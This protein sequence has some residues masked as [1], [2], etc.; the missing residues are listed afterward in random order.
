MSRPVVFSRSQSY[1]PRMRRLRLILPLC[2]LLFL[3]FSASALAPEREGTRVEVIAPSTPVLDDYPPVYIRAERGGR[4]DLDYHG[5]VWMWTDGPWIRPYH[6]LFTP[7]DQGVIRMPM[8]FS[9]PVLQRIETYELGNGAP[10]STWSN[11][12]LPVAEG[13]PRLWW[14]AIDACAEPGL[15][16]CLSASGAAPAVPGVVAVGLK[17]IVRRVGR[18]QWRLV[19]DPDLAEADRDALEARLRHDNDRRLDEAIASNRGSLLLLREEMGGGPLPDLLLIPR[20]T[21]ADAIAVPVGAQ[22]LAPSDGGLIGAWADVP[23]AAGIFHALK[24]GSAYA[25]WGGRILLAAEGGRQ[26]L[27]AGYGPREVVS[28]LKPGAEGAWTKRETATD[29]FHLRLE[30]PASPFV[31]LVEEPGMNGRRYALAAS[32]VFVNR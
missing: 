14:G 7:L 12:I 11:P 4:P 29:D 26:A 10:I 1:N 6:I 32:S 24:R 15:D 25:A 8:R 20:P 17:A 13:A 27:I 18:E 30:L 9:G 28:I 22:A 5:E 31:L 19:I 23:T 21:G 3:S 16:F 2:L